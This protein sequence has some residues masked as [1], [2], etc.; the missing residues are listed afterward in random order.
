MN[1][2]KLIDGMILTFSGRIFKAEQVKVNSC[3]GCDAGDFCNKVWSMFHVG[4]KAGCQNF[5]F[6]EIIEEKK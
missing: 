4:E 5:I 1:N 3:T 2:T 6:K